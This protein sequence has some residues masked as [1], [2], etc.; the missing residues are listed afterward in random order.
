MI[1][2]NRKFYD[3]VLDIP[4]GTSGEF[5]I[6]HTEKKAGTE[7]STTSARTQL[8]GG[9]DGEKVTFIHATT[10]HT[11]SEKDDGVWMT[12]YPIEQ[13]QT[14]SMLDGKLYGTVLIGGLGLG[15]A[16]Q[17]IASQPQVDR[18]IV[19]E[20]SQ[21]VVNLVWKHLR[22]PK[23]VEAHVEV[24]DLFEYLKLSKIAV[25][26]SSGNDEVFDCGFYDIWRSDGECTFHETVVPLRR[27][28]LTVVNG[29]LYCWNE[30]I[31]RGQLMMALHTHT[32]MLSNPF[33]GVKQMSLDELATFKPEHGVW[34]DWKV[35][36][37]RAIKNKILQPDDS[38]AMVEYVRMYGRPDLAECM[39]SFLTEGWY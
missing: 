21:D 7:L 19:V 33:P 36:Y 6:K 37:Y 23:R 18:I 4:A 35:P 38:D 22:F 12:D 17:L 14:D 29:P 16:A 1:S 25:E 34:H 31:M 11:L 27:L 8:M 5:S 15:Y 32:T 13:F 3:N 20:K 28:S 10:W 24:A 9:H 26:E 39:E 2:D 30:D